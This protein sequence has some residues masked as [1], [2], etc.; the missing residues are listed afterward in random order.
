MTGMV[1]ESHAGW[2]PET[3]YCMKKPVRRQT[4][5]LTFKTLLQVETPRA[6]RTQPPVP[7]KVSNQSP[8]HAMPCFNSLTGSSKLQLNQTISPSLNHVGKPMKLQQFYT[9]ALW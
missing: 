6:V 2:D 1:R 8:K 4:V 5:E 9:L 3:F 7:Q